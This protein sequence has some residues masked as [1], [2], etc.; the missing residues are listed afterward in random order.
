[1]ATPRVSDLLASGALPGAELVAGAAKID[2]PVL[3]VQ[4]LARDDPQ[5]RAD[6]VCLVDLSDYVGRSATGLYLIDV[7]L[8]KLTD[9]RASALVI[10]E[11]GKRD[12]PLAA[13]RLAER[14]GVPLIV[15]DQSTALLALEL[16]L[17][18]RQPEVQAAHQLRTLAVALRANSGSLRSIV[19][20][21]SRTMDSTVAALAADRSLV[22]GTAPEVAL[23]LDFSAPTTAA[24]DTGSYAA[25]PV[26]SVSNSPQLW[27]V[28]YHPHGGALWRQSALDALAQAEG[29]V[30]AFLANEIL[31]AERNARSSSTLLSELLNLGGDISS[32]SATLA[33]QL[34]WQLSGWH[35]G[36]YFLRLDRS[37]TDVGTGINLA[38]PAVAADLKKALLG[39]GVAV[40]PIVELADGWATWIT[41]RRPSPPTS[42]TPLVD[43]VT[44]GVRRYLALAGSVSMVAGIGRQASNSPGL[45]ESLKSARDA[46]LNAAIAETAGGVRHV[47]M[48][49]ATAFL[50]AAFEGSAMRESAYNLL[51][52]LLA[53]PN[54]ED[55]LLTLETYLDLNGNVVET[56]DRVKKHRNTV[57]HHIKRACD[58]LG[59]DLNDPSQR[60]AVWLACHSQR[61]PRH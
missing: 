8:R 15:T 56:A 57:T 1:M 33:A 61:L 36:I 54:G 32:S 29:Y 20:A 4:T 45:A 46:A 21:V 23:D 17:W 34:G 11:I 14:C 31:L 25:Y 26:L 47:D 40:G 48:L 59:V 27:L 6:T 51:A 9:A 42:I 24:V 39:S 28:A 18:I 52:T 37:N 19:T 35:T 3:D 60:L 12:L 53:D 2:H 50:A 43:G 55:L 41:S 30:K 10:C 5:P 13:H 16:T 49:G 22:A 38:P 58:L 7:L 44:Q